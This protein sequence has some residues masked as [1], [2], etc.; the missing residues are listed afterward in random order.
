MRSGLDG[1]GWLTCKVSFI[2]V[3]SIILF[4]YPLNLVLNNISTHRF[5]NLKKLKCHNQNFMKRKYQQNIDENFHE[6]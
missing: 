6:I 3:F 4:Y 2:F 1:V 5:N